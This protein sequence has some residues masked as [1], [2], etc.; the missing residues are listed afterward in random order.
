MSWTDRPDDCACCGDEPGAVKSN[1]RV[2]RLLHSK[3]IDP[4]TAAFSRKE[5]TQPEGACSD[6]CGEADGG[7]IDRCDS[8]TDD[9]LRERACALA[10]IR[11]GRKGQGA[12]V[13]NVAD[14]RAIRHEAAPNGRAVY[15]YDDPMLENRHHAVMRVSSS[16]PRSD[17]IDIQTAIVKAFSRKVEPS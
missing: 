12:L 1:E 5:L 4:A 13:A 15:V 6:V 3:I 2:A 16:V 14:L 11:P 9:E 8:V 10:D 7:S 17:F